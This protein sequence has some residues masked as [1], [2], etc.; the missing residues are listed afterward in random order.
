VFNVG[1]ATT[2]PGLWQRWLGSVDGLLQEFYLSYSTR[3]NASGATWSSYENEISACVAQHKSCWFHTGEYS[4][5][6]TAQTRQYALASFL[7]ATDGRQLLAVGGSP[8]PPVQPQLMLGGR[9]TLMF[10]AGRAWLRYF[11]QGIAVVNPS[12]SAAVIPLQGTYLD[13]AGHR[14]STVTLGPASGAALEAAADAGH[15]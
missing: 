2:F 7:L 5:D 1:Y 15:G 12:G 10:Q 8:S 4:A 13:G 3:P 11:A 6:I 9:L 14:I